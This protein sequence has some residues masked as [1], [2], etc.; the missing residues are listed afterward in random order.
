VADGMTGTAQFSCE[1]RQ[2]AL[3]GINVIGLRLLFCRHEY[4]RIVTGQ[5]ST[6]LKNW[7]RKNDNFFELVCNEVRLLY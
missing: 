5:L 2:I 4:I 6:G 1:L 7:S 3:V